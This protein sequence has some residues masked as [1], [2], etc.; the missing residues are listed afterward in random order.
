MFTMRLAAAKASFFDRERVIRATDAAARRQLSRL[1]AFTRT[2]ARSSI[3]QRRKISLPGAPPS[4]HVGTLRAGILFAYEAERKTVVIGPTSTGGRG[5]APGLLERGG[6]AVLGGKR[7]VYRA[8][9]YMRPAFDA[10]LK[11]LPELF[12]KTVRG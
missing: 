9:P 7:A 11:R 5:E 4:S 2:R 8:R 10:E 12:R 3:R 6:L 1:G